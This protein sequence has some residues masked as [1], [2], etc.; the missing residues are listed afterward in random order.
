MIF[1]K[2]DKTDISMKKI[3]VS[4]F[5]L[6]LLLQKVAIG[7]VD[8]QERRKMLAKNVGGTLATYAAPPMLESGFVDYDKLITELK[9]LHANTYH[10][11][12]RAG[13]TDLNALKVFLP[14]A[15]K[16]KIKV[17]VT[18][19][20]PSESPPLSSHYSEPYRLD[21]EQWSIALAKLSLEYP[22]LVAWSI[23][24]FVHNLK[25]FTPSYVKQ[26]LDA[27]RAINPT[28][29]FF[30]C[31]YYKQTDSAFAKNYGSIIDGILFP[32]RSES[33]VASLTDPFQVETEINKIRTLFN[34][35]LLVYLDVYASP[36][37]HLGASTAEY[38]KEVVR[39]GLAAADGVLIY[40]HQD[41]VKFPEKFEI[42]QRA[43]KKGLKKQ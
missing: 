28:L 3:I 22:N 16:A 40:R 17:W 23:D 39:A 21:F 43:F 34:N 18:L 42:V 25:L 10:W 38:V 33:V 15:E 7:Q 1:I 20:P 6:S 13:K 31:C 2:I 36:H 19:V 41:P 5:L 35:G 12:D 11:L 32:Y 37:S 4:V 30:P 9:S 26:F 29:A 8:M 14:M 24:D 27:G